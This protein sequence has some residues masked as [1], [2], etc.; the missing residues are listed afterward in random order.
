M[1][2]FFFDDGDVEVFCPPLLVLLGFLRREGGDGKRRF[3]AL[4]LL[5]R[6]D[7]A[8]SCR[9]PARS[10]RR[11]ERSAPRCLYPVDQA[12]GKNRKGPTTP[13]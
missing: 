7:V 13:E 1:L 11:T 2:V 5:P 12:D 6:R 10:V 8:E 9:V 4:Q 3:R